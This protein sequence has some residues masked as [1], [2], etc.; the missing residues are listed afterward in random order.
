MIGWSHL[1]LG[2]CDVSLRIIDYA[3][4]TI[5]LPNPTPQARPLGRRLQEF[6]L[7]SYSSQPSKL[8][9]TG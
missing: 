8:F 7:Q 6:V 9:D 3:H 4:T 2:R 1:H 5:S